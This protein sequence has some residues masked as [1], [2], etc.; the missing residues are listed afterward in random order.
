MHCLWPSLGGGGAS[1]GGRHCLWPHPKEGGEAYLK[2]VDWD[3]CEMEKKKTNGQ[4]DST[5]NTN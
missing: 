4:T 5:A 3:M 1:P 2:S